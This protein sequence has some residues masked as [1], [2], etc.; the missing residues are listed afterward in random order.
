M[1][2]WLTA[3]LLAAIVAAPLLQAQRANPAPSFA[4][5]FGSGAAHGAGFGA[6]SGAGR[7]LQRSPIFPGSP[8]FYA[9][10]TYPPVAPA[11]PANPQVVFLASPPAAQ[12][13]KEEAKPQP[14][15]IELQGGRYV[16]LGETQ[17]ADGNAL[18]PFSANDSNSS[19]AKPS[20]SLSLPPAVLVYRDGHQERVRDYT[21]ASGILYARGNYWTD[22]YWNKR[23]PLAALNLPASLRASESNG[24]Q[25]VLPASS[26]E[27]VTRP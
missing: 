18:T 23:I 24:V 27:V 2:R 15:M 8:Y 7:G 20:A 26:N 25:F 17:K 9:D 16:R 14:L 6:H 10:G 5:S 12:P 4:I 3:G 19:L 1:L 21:I 11:E 22:G 13:A